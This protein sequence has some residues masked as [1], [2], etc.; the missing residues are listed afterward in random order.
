[1][2]FEALVFSIYLLFPVIS[3]WQGHF[4]QTV[5][6]SVV[7]QNVKDDAKKEIA[8]ILD[9]Y[10]NFVK[11]S[12]NLFR[13]NSVDEILG[14][15]GILALQYKTSSGSLRLFEFGD[16]RF[17]LSPS[18][19]NGKNLI[20]V[21]SD[22]I[23]RT[24]YDEAFRKAETISWKEGSSGSFIANRKTY[25][26]SDPLPKKTFLKKYVFQKNAEASKNE[27][28]LP[29]KDM[30]LYSRN[31]VRMWDEDFENKKIQDVKFDL[32]G[33]PVKIDFY[34]VVKDSDSGKESNVLKKT[35]VSSF[36]SEG[37]VLAQEETYFFKTPDVLTGTE[38]KDSFLKRRNVYT[39]T[40]KSDFPDTKFYEDGKLRLSVEYSSNEN[41][42]STVFFDEGASIKSVY[43]DGV[44]VSES[45]YSNGK[46]I[47]RRDLN[48]N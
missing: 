38:T 47:Y 3:P 40:A 39:Y 19:Y 37:R 28:Q 24:L 12:S 15:L 45:T 44:K 6:K 35:Q 21:N 23:V 10:S 30:E 31:P 11:E 18:I 29:E 36:N 20:S 25:I 4:E 13:D 17:S 33:N 43:K 46:E 27:N 5:K 48:A 16:E 2:D 22:Y 14:T 41:Y 7:Q 32:K 8:A 34:D 1:M 9:S 42:E 26:Y